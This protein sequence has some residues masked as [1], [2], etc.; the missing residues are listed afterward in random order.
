MVTGEVADLPAVPPKG[1]RQLRFAEI[2]DSGEDV[3][4]EFYVPALSHATSYDRS[5]G[6]FSASALSVAARGVARFIAGGG[7]MRLLIGVQVSED[8]A[9]ALRGEA[10]IPEVLAR[11]MAQSLVVADDVEKNRLAV[12]AWLA[13]TGRLEAKVA[14]KVDASGKPVT[15][16]EGYFHEKIGILTDEAGD[17][18]AFQGSNNET[19]RGWSFNFESFS[20]YRSWDASAGYCQ[21]WREK[22]AN[23][24]AGEVPGYKI[25]PLPQ[26]AVQKLLEFLPD[27]EPDEWFDPEERPR[28]GQAGALA[29]FVQVAP[30]LPNA[31]LLGEATVGLDPFPHQRLVSERLAGQY[32][33]S[34]LV[35]DEVG[36]GKTISAG[37]ALRRLLLARQIE[38]VLIMAPANVCPQWQDE[39][40][41]KFGLWVPRLDGGKVYGAY[42]GDESTVAEGSNPYAAYPFLLVSS[43]LA[44]MDE[45]R[46]MI[47]EAPRLDLLIVDEA[48]H[49][50]RQGTANLRDYRPSRLLRLLDELRESSP[51]RA[52]WLLTATPMQVHPVELLDLLKHV[53]LSGELAE[54]PSFER[55]FGELAK[56][57]SKVD[58]AVLANALAG[59]RRPP[60]DATSQTLLDRAAGRLNVTGRERLRNFIHSEDPKAEAEALGPQGREELKG[61]LR[62]MSPVGQ[63]MTRHNRETLKR[64]RNQGLLQQPI[65][66]R[67]VQSDPVVFDA[68]EEE[69]Y[70]ELEDLIDRL[71]E[72]NQTHRNAG[73]VL[74]IY[75]RRL[76]S[77]WGA[78]KRTLEKRLNKERGIG[79]F[80][81]EVSDDLASP[82]VSGID[83]RQV[84]RLSD[85]DTAAIR[86][87]LKRIDTVS[88][89]KFERLRKDL[90]E[91]RGAGA[92]VIVFTQFTDTLGYL[93]D[94]LAGVYRS[95]LATFGGNMGRRLDP[96][97]NDWYK[98]SKQQLVDAVRAGEVRVLLATDSASEGL[99]LQACSRVINYDL[100]WNPM[101]VE[102]RIGRIDRIGQQEPVIRVRNYVIP[103][104]V[105]QQVYAALANRIDLFSGLV[106]RLQPI[107]GATE[108]AFNAI[109]K[110]PRS[111]RRA[112]VRSTVS[113]LISQVDELESKGID[114]DL[115]T[116]DPMPLPDY[117][118]PPVTLK[119]LESLALLEL[120]LRLGSDGRPFSFDPARVSRDKEDWLALATYGHPDLEAELARVAQNDAALLIKEE[121]GV[122]VAVRADRSPPQLVER[123]EDCRGLGDPLARGD[124]EQLADAILSDAL[125]ARHERYAHYEAGQSVET[126]VT[127]RDEFRNVLR[128]KI[129]ALAA[130][131]QLTTGDEVD[132]AN[133]WR[134]LVKTS[135]DG[136]QYADSFVKALGMGTSQWLPSRAD[137]NAAAT[138]P[139]ADLQV[140]ASAPAH[141][142]ID[143]MKRWKQLQG[144]SDYGVRKSGKASS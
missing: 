4:T 73:F 123:L 71:L 37:M 83:D 106:G 60:L 8:D 27:E 121:G 80:E 44:R 14:V 96:A 126:A 132:P 12:L 82:E 26:A 33:R 85:E 16:A 102:Q 118:Q 67:D 130:V 22:F 115:L 38:R 63:H 62:H 117:P 142:T 1:L 135:N 133:V 74:T 94:K 77:S 25:M 20:V 101:R 47:A 87:W 2:Y 64:Y 72:V 36:L 136:W 129:V 65:A 31:Q 15:G 108:S 30:R 124:A 19:A 99:N 10:E 11:K 110:A 61:W 50:R 28:R 68:V 107:L 105:E 24:W 46:R 134:D 51:P 128:R 29:R 40:F 34:W 141:A 56:P 111:E 6:Y 104:T 144:R 137:V 52:T 97:T 113:E 69:L 125:K 140:E 88:D 114:I 39:L 59:T 116:D 41:E 54:W 48:H 35:A 138:R 70:G 53:G 103:G 79:D 89:S 66:E 43:H 7:R 23:R 109:F 100:P 95:E 17:S 3:L 81:E 21:G 49:A 120:N 127:I 75:R 119:E 91:A 13:Q 86:D 57:S 58:W 32:P 9:G 78:I 139:V 90:D 98:V 18:V 84:V 55:F 42:P 93:R 45:H 5:V 112:A 143:L 92:A 131:E 122:A 76:T